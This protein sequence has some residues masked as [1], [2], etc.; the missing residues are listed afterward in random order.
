ML[1]RMEV[2][3]MK[4]KQDMVYK[5]LCR[6][7]EGNGYPPTVREIAEKIRPCS[8]SQVV[9][10]LRNLEKLGLVQVRKESPRAIKVVGYKFVKEL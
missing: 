4:S 9:H 5:I 6:Y 1:Y 3:E 10:Y 8:T 2:R 7:L